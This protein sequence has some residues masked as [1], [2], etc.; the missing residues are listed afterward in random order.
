YYRTIA[1]ATALPIVL[2][3][4]PRFSEFDLTLPFLERL[5]ALPTVRYLKDAS[6]NT[7]RL[8]TLLNR[9]GHRLRVFA[10][11]AHVPALVMLLGGV[12]WMAGPACLI[13]RE[14]VRL[15]ERCRAGDWSGA[16]ELQRRLWEINTLFQKYSLA[17][18]IKAG[19][20]VQGF[21]VGPPIPP[22]PPLD[23][24]AREEIAAALAR[25]ASP[26]HG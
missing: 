8:L 5:V 10:A 14:S 2:Y 6:T 18:C 24:A 19:L 1:E 16:M 15:Y 4:N 11:S 12:G 20:E 13:P 26:L 17:A 23:E 7:G 25:V 22:Q 9:F 21:E 3:T